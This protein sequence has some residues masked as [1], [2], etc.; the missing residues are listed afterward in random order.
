MSEF[1]PR[2]LEGLD[3]LT[4]SFSQADL[5]MTHQELMEVENYLRAFDE[6]LS[7][8]GDGKDDLAMEKARARE[9]KGFASMIKRSDMEEMF[10][11]QNQDPHDP[12]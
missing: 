10:R 8:L 9:P 4:N 3:K 1:T 11:L 2:Q 7:L 5:F 6:E 12:A